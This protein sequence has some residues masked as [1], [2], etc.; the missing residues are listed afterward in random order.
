MDG[1]DSSMVY[2]LIVIVSSERHNLG[3]SSHEYPMHGMHEIGVYV[4]IG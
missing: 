1:W 3:T 4:H 2:R